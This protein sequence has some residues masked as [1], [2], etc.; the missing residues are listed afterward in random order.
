MRLDLEDEASLRAAVQ[1]VK[2]DIII[3]TAAYTKVDQA[4]DEPQISMQVNGI[5]PG[6]LAE[7]AKKCGAT[8]IQISTDCVFDGRLNRPYR[9]S[10][11]TNPISTYGT[12]KLKG[13]VAVSNATDN[14]I[15]IRVAWV[16]S[17]YGQNFYTKMLALAKQKNQISVVTDQIGNPTHAKYIA[18]RLLSVCEKQR[19]GQKDLLGTI[20][21]LAEPIEM[22]RFEFARQIFADNNLDCIVE[23]ITSDKRPT[24]AKRPANSRLVSTIE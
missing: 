12:S 21:H 20:Q 18:K 1:A 24:K 8:I 2:P 14:F 19:G 22:T 11:E 10:D 16:Y 3:N 5:A 15:I 23:P 9:P 7:E 6:I 13:E 4:E 17:S